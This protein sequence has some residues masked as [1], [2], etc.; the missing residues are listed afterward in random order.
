VSKNSSGRRVTSTT[1]III[2]NAVL[3]NTGRSDH[4][5]QHGAKAVPE[6]EANARL[7][8]A[9]P[10]L[11]EALQWAMAELRGSTKYTNPQ[12]ALN[13]FDKAETALAKAA[14]S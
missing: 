14:Q 11:Y 3:R 8:A 6:A 5:L 4:R 12:Q 7:I 9:A 1:G 2:C 13:C 10:D